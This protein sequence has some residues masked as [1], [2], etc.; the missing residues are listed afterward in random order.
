VKAVLL[1]SHGSNS[2][3]LA[4][5]AR[6]ARPFRRAGGHRLWARFGYPDGLFSAAELRHGSWRRNRNVAHARFPADLV[7]MAR[8]K[9]PPATLDERDFAWLRDRP[10]GFRLDGAGPLACGRYGRRVQPALKG[11]SGGG[12]LGD[13]R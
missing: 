3:P 6:S 11:R 10:A 5:G 12:L 2:A 13:G 4:D 9:L 8:Q 1:N 7:D